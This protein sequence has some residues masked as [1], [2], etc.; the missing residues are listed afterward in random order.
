MAGALWL[1]ML[2]D[3]KSTY[4]IPDIP[5]ELMVKFG[6]V[7]KRAVPEF[8]A[9]QAARPIREGTIKQGSNL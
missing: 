2:T 1:R 4:A 5:F 9:E 3:I 7:P 8:L 6:R